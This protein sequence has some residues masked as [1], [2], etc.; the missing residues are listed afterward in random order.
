MLIEVFGEYAN[1]IL[2]QFLERP[3]EVAF[4]NRDE[5]VSDCQQEVA[6]EVKLHLLGVNLEFRLGNVDLRKDSPLPGVK[7]LKLYLHPEVN[8]LHFDLEVAS[9]W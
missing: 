2:H 3:S 6:P 1:L 9:D 8:P 5:Q 4:Q 7:L